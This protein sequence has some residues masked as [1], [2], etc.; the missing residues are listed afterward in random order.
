MTPAD[1]STHTP[2]RPIRIE[3]DLWKPFGD[4][5]GDRNR[6]TL[7]RQFIA[8]YLRRPG[9]KLPERPPARRADT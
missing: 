9:A 1:R 4:L 5:V 2:H 6:S 7:I 8:W 3:E